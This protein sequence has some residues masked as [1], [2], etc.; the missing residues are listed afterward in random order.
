MRVILFRLGLIWTMACEAA[1]AGQVMHDADHRRVTLSDRKHNLALR[2]CYDDRCILDQVIVRGRDVIGNAGVYSSVRLNNREHTTQ[3]GIPSPTVSVDDD[4]VAV[5]GI[6]FGGDGVSI[7]ETWSFRVEADH[8]QW[9]I[10]RRYLTGVVVDNVS[11]P[12]WTFKDLS[13]WT[14]AILGTG[15]VAWFRLFDAP[16]AAYGVQTGPV[17]LWNKDIGACLRIEPT[18]PQGHHIAVRFRRDPQGRLSCDYHLSQREFTPRISQ[19]RFLGCPNKPTNA[20]PSESQEVWKPFDVSPGEVSVGYRLSAPDYA[21]AYGRGDLRGI[22]EPAVREVCNTIARLGVIDDKIIGS[23]GWYSGYAVLH[24]PWLAQLGLVI[25]DP[26]Y[27]RNYAATINDQR[28]QAI[29]PDGR[30]KSRW[31]YGPWDAMPGTYDPSGFYECQWGYLL[32][33]QPCWII[34]V[35]EQFDLSGDVQW[36]QAQKTA[37]ERVL[38]FMLRRDSNCNGLVE[39]MTDSHA[40]HRAGDWLDAVWVSF[41]A[42][43]INAQMYYVMTLW[44]DCEDVLGD[45]DRAARYRAAAAKLRASYNRTIDEG[46][47]WNPDHKWYVHWRDKDGSVHGDNLVLPVNFMSIAYGLCE[48]PARRDA[49]LAQTEAAMQKERLFFWPTCIFS[50]RED[51]GLPL[52]WPFPSYENGDIFLAWGEVAIR[53]YVQYDPSIAVRYVK[54]VLDQYD[55]D[56]LAFQRYLRKTQR[57]AGSDILSNMANPLV[58]LYRNIYGIQPKWN[59]LYLEPHLAPELDG[60]Q[61]TY[62]L[63]GQRYSMD[64]CMKRYRI[65][66]NEF[67]ISDGRAFGANIQGNTLEYFS[68]NRKSPSLSLTRSDAIPV[69]V[70]IDAWPENGVRKWTETYAVAKTSV[71]HVLSDLPPATAFALYRNG[72]PA[73]IVQSDAAGNIVFDHSSAVPGPQ[74]FVLA[75]RT[76]SSDSQKPLQPTNSGN[77][78]N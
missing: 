32:E 8:I 70:G 68:S 23:N 77:D 43:S 55:K 11:F 41:E 74:M 40:E 71:R 69:D 12:G 25:D 49:I 28:E 13:T 27:T 4:R 59:R 66:G 33:S 26:A 1:M 14:G 30:V 62:W 16:L 54:N 48:D 63:R 58:G 53:A 61:L 19:Y 64:L 22:S 51:E 18:V 20:L 35:S 5:T 42:A 7:E 44:A 38:D 29:G 37:C 56:G 73:E 34:N 24:E 9:Q 46:G 65:A 6:R 39:L 3:S 52:N 47:F 21:Q 67:A 78:R 10:T 75:P 2:L 60:T 76:E 50:Y 15:G 45:R 57:G 36:L 17:T 31:A 72:G